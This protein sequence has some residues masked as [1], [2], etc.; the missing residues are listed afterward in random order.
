MMLQIEKLVSGDIFGYAL[1][2]LTAVMPVEIL[3][4]LVFGTIGTGYY[5][6]QGSAIM[7]L[8]MFVLIGGVTIMEGPLSFIQGIVAVFILVIA[9]I[10]YLLLQRF[11]VE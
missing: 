4:L 1:D 11:N 5:M 7:P 2:I 3:A 10:A 9:G 8:I 6:V